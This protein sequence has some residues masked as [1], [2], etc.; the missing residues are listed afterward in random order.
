[1]STNVLDRLGLTPSVTGTAALATGEKPYTTLHFGTLDVP[2]GSLLDLV[3]D[4]EGLLPPRTGHLGNWEDIALC[5]SGPM[6]FNTAVC[7]GG[8]GYPLVYGFTRTEAHTEGGDDVYLPGSLVDGGRRTTLPLHTWDGRAFVRRDRSRPLFCALTQ[9]ELDGELVPLVELHWRR[10]AT[11]PGY[12]F[13]QWAT[14]LA[15]HAALVTD[16]LCLLLAE[17]AARQNP[18]AAFAELIS[19]AVRLDGSVGRCEVRRHGMGYAIEDHVYPSARAFAEE[20]L[21]AVQALT[22]PRAFFSRMGEVPPVL[23]VISIQLSSVLFGLLGSHLPDRSGLPPESPF[24]THLHWGA[25]AMAGCPPRRG[26]YLARKTTVRSLR[27][28]TGP[29][30][31]D[32]AEVR[33]LCFALLPAQIFML[34]P[35]DSEQQDRELLAD[36]FKVVLAADPG[37]THDTTVTWLSTYKDRLSPYLRGRFRDGSGVPTDA[38]RRAPAAPAEPEGFRDLTFRQA[39]GVVAAFE[40]ALG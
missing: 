31:R 27:A 24:V 30:V 32:F 14:F 12:R 20:A 38:V 19:H 22:E 25:R 37:T 26:G 8:Y 36:L 16:M 15:D 6:D 33:P 3:R 11:V 29:L 1:M 2:V 5:R 9:A 13:R 4:T 28:I 34:C 7:A 18:R 10:M 23:P 17:A 40:E 21:L 35:P 39:C